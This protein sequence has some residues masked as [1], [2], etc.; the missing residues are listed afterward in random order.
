M[1]Y[2][3]MKRAEEADNVLSRDGVERTREHIR[4]GERLVTALRD[5]IDEQEAEGSPTDASECLLRNVLVHLDWLRK[6]S[7]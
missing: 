2:G 4:Q 5:L 1:T 3:E 6:H 7:S